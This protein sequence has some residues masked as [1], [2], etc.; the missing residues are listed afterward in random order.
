[1][2][3]GEMKGVVEIIRGYVYYKMFFL[4]EGID[5]L[6]D[7]QCNCQKC[8]VNVKNLKSQIWKY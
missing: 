2:E 4:M 3:D 5:I 1:M 7:K 8:D 6:E